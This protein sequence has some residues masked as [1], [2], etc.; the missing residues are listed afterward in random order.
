MVSHV[1]KVSGLQL[2]LIH[3]PRGEF[4]LMLLGARSD[5]QGPVTQSDGL[6]RLILQLDKQPILYIDLVNGNVAS[7]LRL[8]Q[9][10]N[11][12]GMVKVKDDRVLWIQSSEP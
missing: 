10:E 4:V 5:S 8:H 2:F 7:T 12:E 1:R 3:S 11:T 9:N 6:L